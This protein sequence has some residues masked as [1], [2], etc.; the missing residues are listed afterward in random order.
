MTENPN[1]SQ[2][3]HQS[4]LYNFQNGLHEA[5]TFQENAKTPQKN[6]EAISSEKVVPLGR[7]PHPTQ[8]QQVGPN[9]NQISL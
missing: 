3:F 5:I 2:S 8:A 6:I 9:N 4:A 1:L 7:E